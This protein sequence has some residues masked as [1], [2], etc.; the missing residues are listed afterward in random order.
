MIVLCCGTELLSNTPFL[1][2]GLIHICTFV[3]LLLSGERNFC[4]ALNA[5][6]VAALPTDLPSFVGNYAD[7]L[8]LVMHRLVMDGPRKL[9]LLYDCFLTIMANM[10]AYIKTLC[11][12][13]SVRVFSLF[14]RFCR[15]R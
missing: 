13:S 8:F 3:L 11:M 4:V 6:F 14:Q 5:P 9:A 10:S 7:T 1:Q 15:R 2:V 12:P